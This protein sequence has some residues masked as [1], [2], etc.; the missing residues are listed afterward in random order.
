MT[1]D[2]ALHLLSARTDGPLSADQQRALDAWLAEA[3][4]HQMLA[5]A[6]RVQHGELRTA[7][8]PR[9]EAARQTAA[10]VARQLTEPPSPARERIARRWWRFLVAPVPAACAAALLV[11]TGLLVFR[12]SQ[13]PR[14]HGLALAQA[15][16]DVFEDVGLKPRKKEQAPATETLAVGQ[17]LATRAGEKRR[18]TLPDG[19]FLYLNQNTS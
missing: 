19:S 1:H 3:A 8:E 16:P 4:D 2:E 9:R 13:P 12:G 7:F 10:A 15:T 5:E 6:F 14:S 18:V 17:T 11:G